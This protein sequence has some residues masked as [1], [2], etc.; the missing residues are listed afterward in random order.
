MAVTAIVLGA[1]EAQV[2]AYQLFRLL[3]VLMA[4]PPLIRVAFRWRR[5][6]AAGNG[7]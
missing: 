4:A 5:R 1:D 2:T 6:R 3:F 7:K